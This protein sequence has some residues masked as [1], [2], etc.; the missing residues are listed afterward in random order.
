MADCG[1]KERR[2]MSGDIMYIARDV[3]AS[4]HVTKAHWRRNDMNSIPR[5]FTE[6]GTKV[7][8]MC[9]IEKS[10]QDFNYQIKNGVEIVNS[11]CKVCSY[12]MRKK[13]VA[14]NPQKTREYNNK[15]QKEHRP[16]LNEL[17]RAIAHRNRKTVIDYYGG[18]CVCCGESRIEFIAIDHKG[19]G[20]NKLRKSGFHPPTGKGFYVWI[21]KNNF[22]DFL[23]LL[24]HN[25]NAAKGAYGFCPHEK[26][27]E[28]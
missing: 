5:R 23:Q 1:K 15:Y 16:R 11:R 6:Q 27:R 22:P 9:K 28:L 26:E 20:G 21:I 17:N 7:C 13:Q 19:G 18:K 24:C 12:E 8:S 3:G 4:G 25:C 10:K 2:G 14:D